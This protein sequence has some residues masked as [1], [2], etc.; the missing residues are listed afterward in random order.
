[1]LVVVGLPTGLGGLPSRP[2]FYKRW[3]GASLWF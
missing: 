2:R 1:L 3:T